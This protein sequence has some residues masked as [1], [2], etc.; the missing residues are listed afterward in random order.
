MDKAYA[1]IQRVHRGVKLLFLTVK[2][3]GAAVRREYPAQDIHQCGFSG[4]V[5]TKQGAYLAGIQPE[6]YILKHVVCSKGLVDIFHCQVQAITS[7]FL[8]YKSI[9]FS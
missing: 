5:L 1:G 2:A 9:S 7:V 3:Y 4:A 6:A 8:R